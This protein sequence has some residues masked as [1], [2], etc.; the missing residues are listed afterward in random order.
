[1]INSEIVK[2]YKKIE[3]IDTAK[4]NDNLWDKYIR[5]KSQSIEDYINMEDLPNHNESVILCISEKCNEQLDKIQVDTIINYLNTMFNVNVQIGEPFNVT[6]KI[7]ELKKEC[8]GFW[9]WLNKYIIGNGKRKHKQINHEQFNTDVILNAIHPQK[10]HIVSFTEKIITQREDKILVILDDD[11]YSAGTSFVFGATTMNGNESVVSTYHL[12]DNSW[13][14]KI[15]LHEFGHS[16]GIEHCKQHTCVFNGIIS[17]E[18]LK[19]H[20]IIPCLECCAKIAFATNRTLIDQLTQVNNIVRNIDHIIKG[21]E[22]LNVI[23]ESLSS[24]NLFI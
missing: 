3:H 22:I 18:E 1:M 15:L 8:V 16:L 24:I 19:M 13:L 6:N 4:N 20:P 14:L 7:N 23:E 12:K 2:N 5:E 10:V 11:I 17:F 21:I 9:S